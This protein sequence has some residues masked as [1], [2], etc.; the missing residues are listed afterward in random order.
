M[1]YLEA[2]GHRYFYFAHEGR[3]ARVGERCLV[4]IHGSGGDHGVWS[5]QTDVFEPDFRVIV[6]DLP[7]HG[8]SDDTGRDR[9]EDYA[10]WLKG[11]IDALELEEVVLLGHSMGGAIIQEY[12][13]RYPACLK[14]LV[15][16]G[17]GAKLRV[18]TAILDMVCKDFE[19]MVRL[20]CTYAYSEKV[21]AETVREGFEMLCRNS[22]AVLH[23]DFLA[24]DRFDSTER[25]KD[26]NIPTL[27]ICGDEDQ[28]T[29]P[30]YSHYLKNT[31]RNS[32]LCIV[33]SAG[34]MVMVERPEDFNAALEGFCRSMQ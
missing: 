11:F 17:T 32:V 27:I 34:H 14:G 29:P 33:E 19:M 31:I 25:L 9:I 5:R 13:V 15:L 12:A 30:L 21:P 7:G 18:S 2:N 23:G 16:V 10:R 24:C 22:P 3:T 26:I 8:L 1:P 6:P 4:F 20:S 28:L